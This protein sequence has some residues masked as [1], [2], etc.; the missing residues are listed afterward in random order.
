VSKTLVQLRREAVAALNTAMEA[1]TL[2]HDAVQADPSSPAGGG[3]VNDAY[4]AR[5]AVRSAS[6][7]LDTNEAAARAAEGMP[8]D[9]DWSWGGLA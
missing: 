8:A 9:Y 3:R 5:A 4:R 2:Y 1:V 7:L 6:R